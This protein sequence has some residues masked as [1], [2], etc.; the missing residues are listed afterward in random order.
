[1][2]VSTYRPYFAPF[3]GFFE[4]IMRSDMMVILDSVQF[5]FGRSWLTRNRFKN[6]KG[7]YWIRV[8]VW[9]RGRG[10][11]R[12]N[13]VKI[14]HERGWAK[15]LR[16]LSMAYKNSPYF[17][18]Q[19]SFWQNLLKQNIM[20]LLDLNLKI[21]RYVMDYLHIDTELILLSDLGIE[22]KEPI[23]TMSICKRLKAD[24]FLAQ[25]SA[26]KYLDMELFQREGIEPCFFLPGVPVYPQLWGEFIPNLSIF[27]LMFNCGPKTV[28]IIKRDLK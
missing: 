23:L 12:I 27:D 7:I 16:G 1:M 6:D 4:K 3:S 17:S 18:E 8:P 2:I 13:E 19:I 5:P 20:R 26:R 25:K 22:E 28:D 15:A 21:I 9:K 14:Y 10:I 24:K 11:Q